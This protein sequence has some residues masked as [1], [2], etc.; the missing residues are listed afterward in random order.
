MKKGGRVCLIFIGVEQET[1][2]ETYTSYGF[3]EMDF[4]Q[5]LSRNPQKKEAS[6]GGS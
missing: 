4:M 6:D 3:E 1:V 5:F 2:K